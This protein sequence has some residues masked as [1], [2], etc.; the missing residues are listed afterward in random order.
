MVEDIILLGLGGHA[1][2]VVDSIERTNEYHIIGFLDR[3][4]RNG[5]YFRN[6]QVLGTDNELEKY[7]N[8]GI[9]NA[10]VTI[11][12]M[13]HGA[14]RNRLYHR[15]KQ[16][17]YRI[18]NIIDH[19]SIISADVKFGEGIFVGKKVIVNANAE[20]QNMCIINTGAIIEHDCCI[21][22]YSHISVGSVLCGGVSVGRETFIGANATIIQ[23]KHIGNHVIVGAGTVIVKNIEDNRIRYGNQEKKRDC[24]EI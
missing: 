10:F 22:E 15:L 4:E 11:G 17:G 20:I 6:Y 24:R 12:F 18:P 5:Q 3:E 21:E 23:E 1:H 16:I 2:S 7:Y 14:T 9:K 13:G 8:C 19:S